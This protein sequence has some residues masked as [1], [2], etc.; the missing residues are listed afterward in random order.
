MK[1]ILTIL[2]FTFYLFI[3]SFGQSIDSLKLSGNE[4]PKEYSISKKNNCISI[5]AC[6][7]Y[8]SPEMYEMLIGKIKSK[9]I[10]NFESKK[11]KGSI[12]YFEFENGFQGAGFLDG[13]LWGGEMK[14]TK[15]HP[16]QYFS[17][18][19]FL[20][21]WSFEKGSTLEKISEEKIKAILK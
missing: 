5:Q 14:P 8:D 15:E 9:E 2:T 20:I 12:M 17:K 4:I 11:D 3:N 1:T 19:N 16:E 10:Q 13:L 21:I 6:T 7:F 18:G